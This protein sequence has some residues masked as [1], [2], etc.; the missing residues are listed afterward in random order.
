M[1]F[2]GHGSATKLSLL[3]KVSECYIRTEVRPPLIIVLAPA[4]R[5]TH[6]T[7]SVDDSTQHTFKEMI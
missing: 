5:L 7:P 4:S 1:H 3:E 6:H 2:L